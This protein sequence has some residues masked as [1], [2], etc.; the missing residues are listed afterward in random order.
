MKKYEQTC[1]FFLI[2]YSKTHFRDSLT[3]AYAWNVLPK[4]RRLIF[5][6]ICLKKLF[7]HPKYLNVKPET[8]YISHCKTLIRLIRRYYLTVVMV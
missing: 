3:H 4:K 7:R 6:N 5:R 2:K 1:N 8:S